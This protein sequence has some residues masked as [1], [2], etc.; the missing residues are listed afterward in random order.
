[1]SETPFTGRVSQMKPCSKFLAAEDLAGLGEVEM[2]IEGVYQFAEE[3]MQDGKKK[4]GFSIGFIKSTKKLIVNATNRKVLAM[5]FGADT[6]KWAGNKIKLF[7]QD[8]IRN[9]NGGATVSGIRIKTHL[10]PSK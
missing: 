2:T 7:V 10:T 1:M 6:T 9:P 5:S 8:G 4:D 3:I